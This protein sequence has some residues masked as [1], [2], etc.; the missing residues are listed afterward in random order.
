MTVK[1]KKLVNTPSVVPTQ[2][3]DGMKI[4]KNCNKHVLYLIMTEMYK[5]FIL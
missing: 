4:E 2:R 5:T 1:F 3:S